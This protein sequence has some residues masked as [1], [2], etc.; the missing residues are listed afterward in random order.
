M[1]DQNVKKLALLQELNHKTF[2]RLA[3]SPVAGI[4]VFA[5]ILITK[6]QRNIFSEDKSEWIKLS[7]EEVLCLPIHS[8]ELVE[9]FCLYDDQNY[10]VPE[11]G[12]KIIDL[13]VF[14]NHSETPNIISLGDGEDFEALQ[15]IKAGEELFI[16]YGTIV[17]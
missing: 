1:S 15:D 16:D 2:I 7:R 17:N 13:V 14:L 8:R 4:G 9:N 12:F 10:Y 11:Y 3:P 5:T 6:G